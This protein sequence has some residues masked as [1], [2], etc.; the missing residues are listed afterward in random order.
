MAM[1]RKTNDTQVVEKGNKTPAL[2][3]DEM[4]RELENL[5]AI[6]VSTDFSSSTLETGT[7]KRM[8]EVHTA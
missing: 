3:C 1:A 4:T 6:V 8:E 2:A 7:V 5:P